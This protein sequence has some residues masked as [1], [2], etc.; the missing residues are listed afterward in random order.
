MNKVGA[1]K[2]NTNA[3]GKHWKIKDTSKMRGHVPWNKGVPM[4][5]EAKQKIIAKKTGKPSGREGKKL[6]AE[7]RKNLSEAHMGQI[8]WNKGKTMPQISGKNHWNWQGGFITETRKRISTLAWK[9]VRKKVYERDNWKC[10]RCGKHCHNDIQCHHVIPY[11]VSQD[12]R[13][14]NLL[15]LCKSCHLKV[16][17]E[18]LST[19][20]NTLLADLEGYGLLKSV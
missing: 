2:G 5:E 15:T 10:Q 6:S 14:E 9:T 19:K 13:M 12:D 20:F 7:Q 16:E 17:R 1:P 11:K 8:A 3:L 18:Y 4:S